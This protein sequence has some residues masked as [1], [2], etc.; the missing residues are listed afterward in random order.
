MGAVSGQVVASFGFVPS[1]SASAESAGFVLG[2]DALTEAFASGTGEAD[3]EG[4]G[5]AAAV[6]LAEG[7]RG[8]AD[9]EGEGEAV[10]SGFSPQL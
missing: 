1:F 2:V 5:D 7:F 3:A 10:S 8:T 9:S 4:E 6:A